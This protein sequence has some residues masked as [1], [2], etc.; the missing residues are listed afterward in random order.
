MDVT[1]AQGVP[2]CQVTFHLWPLGDTCQSPPF[3]Q[4]GA[5]VIRWTSGHHL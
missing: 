5:T 2:Y 3:L 1:G 4:N